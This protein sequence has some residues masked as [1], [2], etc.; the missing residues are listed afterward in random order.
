V[1]GIFLQHGNKAATSG[2]IAARTIGRTMQA[3]RGEM[4]K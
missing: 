3:A 1:G 4:L 2:L